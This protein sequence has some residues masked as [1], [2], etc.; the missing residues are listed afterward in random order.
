M[1]ILCSFFI[2]VALVH[3]RAETVQGVSNHDP[4]LLRE[5]VE[6]GDHT[7]RYIKV[8]P[9]KIEPGKA[10]PLVLFLHGAGGRG[11]D[12]SGQMKDG[13]VQHFTRLQDR[14]P[15]YLIAPQ[16]PPGQLWVD[17]PWKLR[18]HTMPEEPTTWM[19]MTLEL[20]DRMLKEAPVDAARVYVTGLSMGGFGTWDAVQRRPNLFAA[21]VPVCGG[22]DTAQAP[23]IKRVPLWITHGDK[24]NVV[25]TKRSRDMVAA[26]RAAGGSPRYEEFPNTGHN[27]WKP[28]YSN[29]K[30]YTWLFQQ[31]R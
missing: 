20:V 21:A 30:L 5:T 2:L 3:A 18:E 10:Y 6:A 14:Y 4:R 29:P 27:A 23:R 11:K 1:K 19:R 8:Q 17:T 26:L 13:G 28:T 16:V 31:K 25:L 15:H 9:G 24:D 7:L 12:N 22:G